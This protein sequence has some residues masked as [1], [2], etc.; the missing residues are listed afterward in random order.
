MIQYENDY[1]N[2]KKCDVNF[3]LKDLID[4]VTH[5]LPSKNHNCPGG[6]L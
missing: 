4:F 6:Q 3:F 5:K 2:F 1:V